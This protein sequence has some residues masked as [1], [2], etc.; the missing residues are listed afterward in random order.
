MSKLFMTRMACRSVNLSRCPM[1]ITKQFSTHINTSMVMPHIQSPSPLVLDLTLGEGGTA[2]DILT[3][4]SSKV[5]GLDCDPKCSETISRLQK[6]FGERFTGYLGK[7]SELPGLVSRDG[8]VKQKCDVLVM[9]M[10]VST[11]QVMDK[12]R[13]FDMKENG[14]L[15]MRFS[16]DGLNCEQILRSVDFDSLHRI[17]KVY[18][19][20]LKA[21]T[22]ARDILERRFMMEDIETTDQLLEVLRNCHDR[23]DFWEDKT[24]EQKDENIKKVFLGLRMFVNN[25]VNEMEFAVRLA[26]VALRRRGVLVCGGGTEVELSLLTNY[27]FRKSA[28]VTEGEGEGE[29]DVKNIWEVAGRGEEGNSIIFRK[30]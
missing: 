7:W 30:C 9:D 12:K 24:D 20:V 15:D 11:R 8:V 23:D 22:V 19:G 25:E 18:G 10:G 4:T 17:L 14:S 13:G 27:V 21:K 3:N 16:M 28:T 5:V 29:A 1:S 26:E 6:E 2:Q